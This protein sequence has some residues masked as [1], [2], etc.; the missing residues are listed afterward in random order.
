MYI[1]YFIPVFYLDFVFT[2]IPMKIVGENFIQLLHC[3]C[4]AHDNKELETMLIL[5]VLYTVLVLLYIIYY[6]TSCCIGYTPTICI[7]YMSTV[8]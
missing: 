5:C 7:L 4:C 8:V 6:I 1:L 2:H 3:N